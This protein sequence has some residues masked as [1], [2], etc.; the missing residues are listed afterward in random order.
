MNELTETAQATPTQT[1]VTAQAQAETQAPVEQQ[2]QSTPSTNTIPESYDFKVPE[3]SILEGS[4]LETLSALSKEIGASQEQAQKL[5]E[6]TDKLLRQ[7]ASESQAQAQAQIDQ[8]REASVSN[9]EWGGEKLQESLAIAKQVVSQF[10][11]PEL[12]KILTDSG[13][14]NHPDV[15]GMFVKMGRLMQSDSL[16]RGSAAAAPPKTAWEKMYPSN[17]K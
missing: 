3:D 1:E 8:W 4:R 10:A 7:I 15:I 9:K 13:F 17:K 14:G 11:T 2:S 16:V 6:G 5:A 12:Q